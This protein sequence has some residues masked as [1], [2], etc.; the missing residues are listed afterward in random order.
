MTEVSSTLEFLQ[1][2]DLCK[3]QRP[4]VFTPS[5]NDEKLLDTTEENL[6]TI[7]LAFEE[8]N[9]RDIRGYQDEFCLQ[10]AGFE[11]VENKPLHDDL[12]TV[13][14]E[15]TRYAY[16]KDTEKFWMNHLNADYVF[17]YN[18]K[19]PSRVEETRTSGL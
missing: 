9:L 1:N 13:T 16:A 6:N 8:V 18:V 7:R 10:K 11:V 14:K 17:C 3:T 5:Q 19:A 4:Y 2:I 15:E 12:D